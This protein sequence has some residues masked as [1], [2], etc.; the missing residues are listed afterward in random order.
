MKWSLL[1]IIGLAGLTTGGL[2]LTGCRV[3]SA[4]HLRVAFYNVENLFDT[5]DD[6]SRNDDEFTPAGRQKWTEERYRIKLERIARVLQATGPA[7]LIGLAEVE[8]RKVLEDLVAHPLLAPH[9]WDIVHE[10]SPDERGIDV[11][12]LVRRDLLAA[13][14]HVAF[15]SGMISPTRDILYARIRHRSGDTLHV[16]VN[17]WPSRSGGVTQTAA[18]RDTVARRLATLRDSL[19]AMFP[20]TLFLA[21]GDFN[22]TPTDPSVQWLV[23]TGQGMINPFTSLSNE[24]LGSYIYRG[25]WDMLDQIL[26]GPVGNWRLRDAQIL[27]EPWMLYHDAKYG[28]VPNRTYGGPNYYGGY[29]DHLPVWI[30]LERKSGRAA[31]P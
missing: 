14:K 12:L 24:G 29:S 4:D 15:S 3:P 8:N 18:K 22:D 16:W 27:K 5:V 23:S 20:G 31:K 19:V 26:I 10:E 6:P 11:A 2:W 13:D 25:R 17:H 9:G 1:P 28:P 30:D 7:P 21:M